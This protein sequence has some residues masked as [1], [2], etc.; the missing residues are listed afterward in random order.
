MRSRNSDHIMVSTD[1]NKQIAER[2]EVS[3]QWVDPAKTTEKRKQVR[4]L[5]DKRDLNQPSSVPLIPE[6]RSSL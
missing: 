4:D 3:S 1:E 5:C 6:T 2:K